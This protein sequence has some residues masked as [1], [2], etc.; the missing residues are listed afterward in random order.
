MAKSAIHPNLE[1]FNYDKTKLEIFL[2]Q[3]N[4]KIQCNIDYFTR[5]GQNS[6]QNKL[7][8]AISHFEKNVFTQIEPYVSAKNINFKIINQFV[9]VLKT[10]FGKIDPVG[11]AKHKLY[12]FYQTNKNLELFLNTFLRLSKKTKIDNSQALYI[13]YE[14]LSNEFKDQLVNIR[15]VEN[16]NYLILLLYNIDANMKK[17]SKQSQLHIKF[18]TSNFLSIKSPFKSYNLAPTKSSTD[19]R[20]AVVSPVSST[21]TGTH[22]N[23]TDVYNMIRRGPILQE[24]KNRRNSLGLCYYCGEPGHIAIDHRNSALFAIK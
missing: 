2:T 7:S 8:C 14:K 15:K 5:K 20:I 11:I 18:N 13:L 6:E 12:R 1:K 16:F 23:P 4:L 22:P 9:E 19:V 21:T 17:F 10:H 3:L 24:E